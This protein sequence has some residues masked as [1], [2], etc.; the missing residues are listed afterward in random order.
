MYGCASWEDKACTACV[1]LLGCR[2]ANVTAT[3][4]LGAMRIAECA[5]LKGEGYSLLIK[6]QPAWC[7]WVG[8]LSRGGNPPLPCLRSLSQRAPLLCMRPCAGCRPPSHPQPITFYA[9]MCGLA[10]PP[11]SP[12][13]GGS[14]LP[15]RL[16]P[17]YPIIMHL[18]AGS[19]T[20]PS[21]A[22]LLRVRAQAHRP[23]SLSMASSSVRS[24]AARSTSTPQLPWTAGTGEI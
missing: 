18:C 12:C 1:N 24:A 21:D 16:S 9:S 20:P 13:A 14:Q 19:K 2:V 5:R 3:S 17:L 4:S 7:H 11:A 8:A 6:L 23:L 22:P 15:S 10:D